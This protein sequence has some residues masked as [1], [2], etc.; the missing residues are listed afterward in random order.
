[1][2]LAIIVLHLLMTVDNEHDQCVYN[3]PDITVLINMII[4][5]CTISARL[6]STRAI[7]PGAGKKKCSKLDLERPPFVDVILFYNIL[8]HVCVFFPPLKNGTKKHNENIYLPS[9]PSLISGFDP[10]LGRAN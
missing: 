5:I 10:H 9:L 4:L 1:M 6:M 3:D 2:M 7:Q 8:Y